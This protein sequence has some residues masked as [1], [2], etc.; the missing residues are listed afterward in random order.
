MK[1]YDWIVIGAGITG[2]ALAY[3]LT[4]IGCSVLLLEQNQI[5]DNATVYSYGGLPYWAANTPITQKLYKEGIT[6]HRLLSQELMADTQFRELDLILTIPH[7]INPEI[8]HQSYQQCAIPPGLLTVQEACKLEPLLHG[9]FLSGAL[10]VKH[11]HI[12]PQKTAQ[13]YIQAM[14]NLGG[15]IQFQQFL[16]LTTTATKKCTGV[17]TNYT[18][19][20]SDN[21]VVCAGG[22]SRNLLQNMGIYSNSYDGYKI[23]FSHAEMIKTPPV[24][25]KLNSL[26]L[27]ANLQRLQLEMASTHTEELWNQPNYEI[28]PP[29]LDS[30]VVQFLDGS[31][32]IGQISRIFTTPEITVNSTNSTS[33]EKWLRESITQILP[34]LANVP[35]TWHHCLVAF[36][37]DKLPLVGAIP[38]FSGLHIF[39]GFSSPLLIV[40]PLAVRFAKWISGKKDDILAQLSPER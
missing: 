28:V 40:P 32:C 13:A 37:A 14:L 1:N 4:K 15:E 18:T 12:H 21:V 31:L 24:Y 2:T 26:V 22:I 36:T 25:I 16:E 38:E 39:S 5:T 8:I 11:G 27:P 7:D 6:R 19:F 29:I 3:E 33:S 23:Y 34:S 9:D 17:K 10:T 35:G 20:S 30:G